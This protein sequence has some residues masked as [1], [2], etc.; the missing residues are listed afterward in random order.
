[1]LDWF[2]GRCAK[3][4]CSFLQKRTKKLLSVSDSSEFSGSNS[5]PTA[6]DESFLLLFFKKEVLF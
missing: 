6:M 4:S 2:L 5:V 1:M 3:E